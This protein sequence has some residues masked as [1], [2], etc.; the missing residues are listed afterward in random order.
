MDHKHDHSADFKTLFDYYAVKNHW[1]TWI[2]PG[3]TCI[4][5]G[6][7]TGDTA[8][9]MMVYSRGTVLAVEPNPVVRPYLELNCAINSHLGGRFVIA[10][11][12]VT[13]KNIDGLMYRD[14][15][16][17]MCN[18]GLWPLLHPVTQTQYAEHI[19]RQ[20]PVTDISDDNIARISVDGITLETMLDRYLKPEEIEK[21]GFIKIDTE[22]HDI[23]I[24]RNIRNIL[25]KYKPV[26]F[27]EWFREYHH[28]PDSEELFKVID[29]AGYIPF[30]PETMEPADLGT[31]SEDLV[32]LHKDNI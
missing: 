10:S 23:E 5:I 2:Q 28:T 6:G 32:C 20:G 11:E 24:V 17:E 3:M 31:H 8:I 12:A 9:P 27:T 13:N 29:E 7:Y 1:K 22:G 14:H 19:A 16:N 26:L 4:D 21:I 25:V 15:Q 18:G 30:Y